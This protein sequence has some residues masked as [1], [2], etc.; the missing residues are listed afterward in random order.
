MI[1]KTDRIVTAWAEPVS[2]PGWAN[3]PLWI[4]VRDGLGNFREDCLQPD[5]Q[6]VGMQT[7]YHVSSAV[8]REMVAEVEIWRRK[9][10]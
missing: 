1:D 9:K 5:D 10:R 7:L 6:T 4:I 3:R 8:H 2:G